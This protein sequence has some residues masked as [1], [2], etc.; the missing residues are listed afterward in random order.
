MSDNANTGVIKIRGK[1][2]N[3]V[4]L[5]VK[6][7][8]VEHPGWAVTTKVMERTNEHVMVRCVIRD[9]MW[10]KRATGHAEEYRAASNIN[11]TDALE[12]CETSAVGRAL[13]FLGYGGIAIASADDMLR[14][15][16]TI[17]ANEITEIKTRLKE[18][19]GDETAFLA[20]MK[21]TSFEGIQKAAYR[22]ALD[23]IER[24]RRKMEQAK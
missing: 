20:A 6:T 13:A 16:E 23:K 12:N 7:F 15:V 9:E 4:A 11:K 21:A 18:I 10:H 17:D 22:D 1:D 24:K 2:Y 14:G 8:L 3:T 5:R 19:N